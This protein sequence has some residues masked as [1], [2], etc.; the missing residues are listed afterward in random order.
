[1]SFKYL[2]LLGG[3]SYSLISFSQENNSVDNNYSLDYKQK[4]NDIY[5]KAHDN[6]KRDEKQIDNN[7]LVTQ[8]SRD[9]RNYLVKRDINGSQIDK[10]KIEYKDESTE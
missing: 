9:D 8:N 3:F 4:A 10:V 1:M 7:E 5:I 6:K 2:F